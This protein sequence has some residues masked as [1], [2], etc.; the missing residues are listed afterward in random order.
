MPSPSS[1]AAEACRVA[2]PAGDLSLSAFLDT[3]LV[4]AA[5]HLRAHPAETGRRHGPRAD[6]KVGV[7]ISLGGD[8]IIPRLTLLEDDPGAIS[9]V[10][11]HASGP[12]FETV[13]QIVFTTLSRPALKRHV[14]TRFD[15]RSAGVI[16]SPLS[17]HRSL[18]AGA[19]L[20]ACTL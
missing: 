3:A 18:D 14:G 7:R 4:A 2:S 17:A 9:S 20:E 1:R 11:E 19:L 16:L 12:L 5:L 6:R 8:Q 15:L 13:E 10:A